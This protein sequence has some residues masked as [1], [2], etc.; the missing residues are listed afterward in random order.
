MN[1]ALRG[2][3][4]VFCLKC[5]KYFFKIRKNYL[6][7]QVNVLEFRCMKTEERRSH[8]IEEYALADYVTQLNNDLVKESTGTEK[9]LISIILGWFRKH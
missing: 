9:S 6:L 1:D 3:N 2:M 5:I 8:M 4:E 7:L